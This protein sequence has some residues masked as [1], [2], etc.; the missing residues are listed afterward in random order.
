MKFIKSNVIFLLWIV[1]YI[2]F[3]AVVAQDDINT[4][5]VLLIM[6]LVSI[7]VALSPLGEWLLR[8][9]S[10]A[11]KIKTQKDSEYL[12]PIFDA[13]YEDVKENNSRISCNIELY[14]E[15][16]SS[17]N[18]YAFGSNSIS[19]TRG[20][21]EALS[22]EELKGVIAHEFGHM[23]NGNTKVALVM[24]IGNGVFAILWF[25]LKLISL[26]HRSDM[27]YVFAL[28]AIIKF[29]TAVF[30]AM[31]QRHNE[32]MADKFA[33]ENGHGEGLIDTLYM[34]REMEKGQKRSFRERLKASHPD[35]N[36]RIARLEKLQRDETEVGTEL[37]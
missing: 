6:E 1:F 36:N 26:R 28:V 12:M 19:V 25:F 33:H 16:D 3:L 14:I 37:V 32:Y 10:G 21:M 35:L 9:M 34:F 24:T 5:W 17:I 15:E 23:N 29:L 13:V 18:A 27:G 11:K 2:C 31:G 30:I 20:A 7:A 22:E 4:F 8:V